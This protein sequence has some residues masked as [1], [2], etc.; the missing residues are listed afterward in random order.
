MIVALG[1]IAEYSLLNGLPAHGLKTEGVVLEGRQCG[2]EILLCEFPAKAEEL[3]GK[4]RL[5]GAFGFE[6]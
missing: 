4:R 1:T 5:V 6:R 2:L 3:A